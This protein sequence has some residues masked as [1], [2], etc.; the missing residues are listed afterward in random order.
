MMASR[1]SSP[2]LDTAL[3]ELPTPITTIDPPPNDLIPKKRK[4]V[5][6]SPSPL[7][8]F[9]GDMATTPPTTKKSRKGKGIEKPSGTKATKAGSGKKKPQ[10]EYIIFKSLFNYPHN[11]SLRQRYIRFRYWHS[12][13]RTRTIPPVHR[14]NFNRS[15]ARCGYLRPSSYR[16]NFRPSAHCGDLKPS[17]CC[18]NLRLSACR[19]NFRPS[20][21]WHISNS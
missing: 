17:A 21:H 15:S 20:A 5:D 3:P 2:E 6:R 11:F 18:G 10:S 8:V 7:P 12:R 13:S 1:S 4:F 9:D 19:A 14:A 16:A